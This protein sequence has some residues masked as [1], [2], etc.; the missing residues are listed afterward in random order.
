MKSGRKLLFYSWTPIM[1]NESKSSKKFRSSLE[2]FVSSTLQSVINCC[3]NAEKIAFSTRE[4]ENI[5][6]EQQKQLIENLLDTIKKEIEI[7]KA[8]WRILF[9]FNNQQKNLYT[10]FCLA[11]TQLQT[12]IDGFAHVCC[13]VSR[14][15]ISKFHIQL[16]CSFSRYF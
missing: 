3:P 7:H 6:S 11:L 1:S 13:S 10:Q 14:I 16:N 8:K 4:W 5:S 2:Q 12:D 15:F 9:L